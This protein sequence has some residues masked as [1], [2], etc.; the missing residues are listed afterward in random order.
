MEYG[1]WVVVMRAKDQKRLVCYVVLLLA[2]VAGMVYLSRVA[3]IPAASDGRLSGEAGAAA[4]VSTGPLSLTPY[5]YEKR[6]AGRDGIGKIYMG[7]EISRV[8]GHAGIDWL[9]RVEREDEESPGRAV[10]GLKL[11]PD[12]VV[13]DVG[14]GSGYYTFRIAPLVPRGKVI[15]VDVQPEMVEFLATKARKLG[16]SNVESHLGAVDSIGLPAASVDAVILVD[17][18]HEFSHPNEMMQSIVH[19]LRPGGRVYLLEYRAEDLDVPIK[20][21]HKMTQV[22]AIAEMEAVGLQHLRTHDFLPWQHLM[23][24]GR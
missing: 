7:R 9:E 3:T 19:A 18:Y 10:Q 5:P 4:T 17:A 11:A 14:S 8:M 21:L 6:Q 2:V 15:G 20:P 24:F 1:I 22:Q 12:A 23:V 13:A 16:V